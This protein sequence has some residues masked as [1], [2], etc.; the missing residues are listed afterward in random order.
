MPV[1]AMTSRPGHAFLN[2]D[3]LPGAQGAHRAGLLHRKGV[4]SSARVWC[5]ELLRQ[6][7]DYW[8][9]IKLFRWV[10]SGPCRARACAL[11]HAAP[12]RR[13]GQK[14]RGDDVHVSMGSSVRA[15]TVRR[16]WHVPFSIGLD[17]TTP[18]RETVTSA[19]HHGAPVQVAQLSR[20]TSRTKTLP[21]S[22]S[23]NG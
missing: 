22:E 8:A 4:R 18:E 1:S 23:T 20:P 10:E 5:A 9:A 21:P 19:T 6:K 15:S 11:P 12:R 16:E 7:G 14:R 3:A 2:L 17:R 13:V